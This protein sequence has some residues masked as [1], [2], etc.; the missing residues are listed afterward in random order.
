LQIQ[1]M[2]ADV[3][4]AFIE[5]PQ[6]LTFGHHQSNETYRYSLLHHSQYTMVLR[7]VPSCQGRVA[8]FASFVTHE[9]AQRQKSC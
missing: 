5:G 9:Y 1:S 4:K 7:E 8:S 6:S 2:E 3:F